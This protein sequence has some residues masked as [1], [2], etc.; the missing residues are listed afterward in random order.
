MNFAN[1]KKQ[2]LAKITDNDKSKKGSIDIQIKPLVDKINAHPDF[3]TTSSCAG[4]IML[5][6]PS[7][8]KDKYN[9]EWLLSTHEK[10]DID[11]I[12]NSL[13]KLPKD[14]VW[15]RMEPPI[16]H[17]VAKDMDSADILLKQ[18]NDSGF[19]RS[20]LLSFKKR[21]V[22]EIMIPEKMDVPIA[23]DNELVVS[24]DYLQILIKHANSKLD[25]SRTKI[26]ALEKLF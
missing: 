7:L 9:A 22:I 14:P 13:D 6:K 15:F 3:Y 4:R 18:A 19:R 11:Q 12:K 16:I 10:V 23:Q 5:I 25:I 2:A 17:V 21:I 1:V 26:K 24:I 8:T 20:A